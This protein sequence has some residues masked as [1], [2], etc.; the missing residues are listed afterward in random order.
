ML[1]LNTSRKVPDDFVVYAE[2]QIRQLLNSV[3][4]VEFIMLCTSDGFEI[5]LAN[6]KNINNSGKIAAVSSSIL[7]LV[8][9]FVSEI[10]LV[11]CQTITLDA[12]NGKALLTAIPH[13]K[14]PLVLVAMTNKDI[15]LGQIL[16][17]LKSTSELLTRNI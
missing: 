2:K 17:E 13:P 16:Y 4:G 10:N 8:T 14:H 1:D 9:A 5:A 12:E 7:A 11:G 3:S 15:L 6:K